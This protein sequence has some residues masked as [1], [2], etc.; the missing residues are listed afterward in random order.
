M[1]KIIFLGRIS[2]DI[3]MR[4]TQD[5]R[6]ITKFGIAVPRKFKRDGEP[7]ADF[8]NCTAFGKTGENIEK[9]FS[10]G[11]KILIEGEIRTDNYTNRDGQKV[12]SVNVIVQSFE[13]C[14]SAS[15]RQ[16]NNSGVN[17]SFSQSDGFVNIPD[18]MED[19]LPFN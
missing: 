8:F 5:N 18:N 7:E 11:N 16:N 6:A 1:N 14:E 2:R 12:Y 9:Y 4:Y 10:K 3:E 19:D 13:F 17:N 15:A